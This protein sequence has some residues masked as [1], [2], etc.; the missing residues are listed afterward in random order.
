MSRRAWSRVTGSFS[1]FILALMGTLFFF[2]PAMMGTLIAAPFRQAIPESQPADSPADPERVPVVL[3]ALVL[4]NTARA[5]SFQQT[6]QREDPQKWAL[7]GMHVKIHTYDLQGDVDVIDTT[8][9]SRGVIDLDLGERMTGHSLTVYVDGGR[10]RYLSMPV[11]IQEQMAPYFYCYQISEDPTVLRQQVTL[12]LTDPEAIDDDGNGLLH[13]R[14]IVQLK[15]TSYNV[16]L[17][18][19]NNPTFSFQVP[20]D[21][22]VTG[23]RN[24][25]QVVPR[26]QREEFSRFAGGVRIETPIFP[27]F[28]EEDAVM[29][30]GT[31]TIP[32]RWDEDVALTYVADVPIQRIDFAVEVGPLHFIPEKQLGFKLSAGQRVP[33]S[34]VMPKET[35][36]YFAGSIPVGTRI[37]LMVRYGDPPF[38]PLHPVTL[39]IVSILVFG[40]A[41]AVAFGALVAQARKRARSVDVTLLAQELDRQF[42]TGEVDAATYRVEREKI[43]SAGTST[44]REA[45]SSRG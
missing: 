23:L 14:Q 43:V 18:P 35:Q 9:D 40:T 15:N 21:A 32:A 22:E 12:V 45:G 11:T 13:M 16:Y 8:T 28:A 26:L 27:T 17:G 29:L 30:V 31:Y 4:D 25:T 42:A 6:Q 44:L 3:R 36:I 19:Q 38:R 33:A 37:P 34:R 41:L 5:Q 20:V 7:A 10:T 24:G 1:V 2:A 39:L